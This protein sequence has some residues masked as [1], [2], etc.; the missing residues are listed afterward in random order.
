MH[1][2]DGN[3]DLYLF[4][5]AAFSVIFQPGCFNSCDEWSF[6]LRFFYLELHVI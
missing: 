1:A 2:L 6:L 3:T 4:E 5:T